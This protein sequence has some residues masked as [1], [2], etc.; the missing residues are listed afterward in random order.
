MKVV[1]RVDASRQSG[2][3]HVI[4]CLTLANE[5][6]SRGAK[7][8]FLS[9]FMPKHLGCTI[10]AH[11]HGIILLEPPAAT[12]ESDVPLNDI[13]GRW[14]SVTRLEDARECAE[15][16]AQIA[17]DLLVLDHYALGAEWVRL[18]APRHSATL[19][20]DDLAQREHHCDL[21]LDQN[22]GRSEAHYDGLVPD[23]VLRLI[24][25][26]YALVRPEFHRQ[27]TRSL[28]RR[29]G[30]ALQNLL[31]SMGSVDPDN[32]TG[33]FLE[34]LNELSVPADFTITV[35]LGESAP[36]V[37]SVRAQIAKM[38]VP[39][40]LLLG[41]DNMENLMSDADLAIG[42]AGGT[43]WERCSVGL[44]ALLL[45][46]AD[47]QL[48]PAMGLEA[49]G[50]ALHLGDVRHDFW[51]SS[52]QDAMLRCLTDK[53]LV[54]SMSACAASVCD[55]RGAERVADNVFARIRQCAY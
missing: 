7:C 21:L 43:A 3:G 23:N 9:R 20:I 30:G 47:N 22:L 25:P 18:A 28:A 11:Q 55:G 53:E 15:S 37:E 4:R 54:E 39:T 19:V 52:I 6:S 31:L 40:R 45:T 10:Q 26:K 46:I 8:Y 36:H 32:A 48:Q 5:L 44:P 42:G 14:L 24:G 27:R 29:R 13:Y 51:R 34:Q 49:A 33:K 35:V 17:P 16:L 1:L 50:A 12:A 41:V 38:R 2:S